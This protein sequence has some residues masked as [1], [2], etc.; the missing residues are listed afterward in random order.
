MGATSTLSKFTGVAVGAYEDYCELIR[1]LNT[2]H[3]GKPNR[4]KHRLPMECYSL[5]DCEYFFTLCAHHQGTPF[6]DATL[7]GAVVE[8]LLWR[9]SQHDWMLFCYCLMPDH[10]HF[11]VKL[12]P[13]EIRYDKAG[14]RGRVPEGVLDQ[15]GNFKKFTTTQVWWKY[16]GTGRLWQRSS[17]DKIIRYNGSIQAAT[18]YVLDNPVRKG[19]VEKWQDY[20]YSAIVD[21]W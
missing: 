5:S 3:A 7:A 6:T 9:R 11:I 12:P 10:L 2:D 21:R 17:Y 14:A 16:G 4:K 1:F 20:P 18:T 15:V 8:S 13:R 19:L